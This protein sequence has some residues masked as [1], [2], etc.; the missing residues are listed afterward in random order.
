MC[1]PEFAGGTPSPHKQ[2]QGKEAS[3]LFPLDRKKASAAAQGGHDVMAEA[4]AEDNLDNDEGA[5]IVVGPDR[6][7]AFAAAKGKRDVK[8]EAVAEDDLDN[9]EGA[10]VGHLRRKTR[11]I[12]GG[13]GAVAMTGWPKAGQDPDDPADQSGDGLPKAGPA[14]VPLKSEQG[15]TT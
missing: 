2:A 9:D 6:E 7:K 15:A 8:A 1:K 4:I 14:K 10:S 13:R 5:S 3:F 11:A 12:K